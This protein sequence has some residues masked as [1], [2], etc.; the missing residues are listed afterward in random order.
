[1]TTAT[2]RLIP[3]ALTMP[4]RPEWCTLP[5]DHPWDSI[6]P[7]GRESRGHQGLAFGEYVSTGS[8]EFNN[9]IGVQVYDVCVDPRVE[10]EVEMADQAVELAKALIDAATWVVAQEKAALR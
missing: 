5:D 1:M 10:P 3:P 9:A 8:D 6:R 7:D 2:F 4:P